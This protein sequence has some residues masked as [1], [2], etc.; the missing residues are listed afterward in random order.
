MKHF[1]P[2][3][4]AKERLSIMQSNAAKIEEADYMKPLTPEE[5]EFKTGAL[6]DNS[7]K[8]GDIEEQKK[9][10]MDAFKQQIDP[11][12]KQNKQLLLEIR[13]GLAKVTGQ[14]FYMPNYEESIMETYN[15]LGEFISSRRLLPEEKQTARLFI[16]K[17]V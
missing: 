13:T 2:E 14:L 11:L 6:V 9:E 15:E 1:M 10:A 8:L 12:V 17:A 7:I 5:K 16:S 3:L 4:T